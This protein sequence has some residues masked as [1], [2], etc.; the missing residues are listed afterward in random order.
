M[1]AF[2]DLKITAGR[3]APIGNDVRSGGINFALFSAHATKITLCLFDEDGSSEIAQLE[4]PGKT[5]NIWHGFVKGLKPGALYGYRVDGPYAPQDGHRFNA[6]KLLIDPYAKDLFG[7]FMQHDALYGYDVKSPEADMSFD[8]RDSAPY[9]PKCIAGPLNIKFKKTARPNTDM[10]DSIIYEAHIKGLTKRNPDV[11]PAHR[12]TLAGLSDPAMIT[13]LKDLGVTAIELLPVQSFF[14]EPRLTDM[15]LTNYWGY[16]PVNY[17]AM[18]KPYLGPAGAQSWADAVSALHGAG[19]EVILDVVYNHT[20]ESWELGPTLSY[21]GIDNVSYYRLQADKRYYVNHTGCGNTL[22]MSRPE[23][24]DLTIESLRYYASEMRVDGFRFDLGPILGRNPEAFDRG[25]A[26]FKAIEADP[27]LSGVKMIAEPWD[28]GP[29]GYQL[30][31]FPKGWSEW[32]DQYRDCVRSFW[33]GDPGAHQDMAGKLLGSAKN[34]DHSGRTPQAA[35]NFVAAHDGFTLTDTVS[36][37][38]KHNMANGEDN[39]DGHGHNLSENM[40]VEGP[41]D[42][43]FINAV[44]RKRKKNMLATLLLSQGVPMLLAGDE[45]GHSMQ[46][47]NNAYCQDNEITWLNWGG[48]DAELLDFTRELIALRKSRP[49]FT[50]TQ[51]MHGEAVTK[52]GAQ[53]ADWLRADGAKMH[54]GDWENPNFKA[55]ALLLTL[56]DQDTLAVIFN[57]GGDIEVPWLDKDWRREI[58]SAEHQSGHT[59]PADSVSVFAHK[60][61]YIRAD[62]YQPAVEKT[63][64]AYGIIDSYRDISGRVHSADILTKAALLKAMNADIFSGHIPP[65]APETSPAPQVYGAQTLEAHGGIWGVTCALYGLKSDRNWGVGDFEDLA[66]LC[67]TMAAK[68]ADFIGINPVHALFPSAPHLYAPYSPSSREFLNI[69]HIAPDMI[70]EDTGRAPQNLQNLRDAEIVDYGKIYAAKMDA[71]EAAFENFQTLPRTSN[72]KKDFA[73]FV[74]S[75]GKPLA[76]HALFDALFEA[77]PKSEQTYDG[78]HNFDDKYQNPNSAS[79]KTFAAQNADRIDFYTYLQWIAQTQI[80]AAQTRAMAAGMKTGLYLDFAVGVVPGGSDA[81]RRPKAFARGVS[82]GA[83]G[84]MANPDGQKWGLLPFD[85][86]HLAKTDFKDYRAALKKSLSLGGAVRI[87]HILGLLRSFWIPDKGGAGAYVRYPF[88]ALMT[89]IAQDSTACECVVFGEDLGTVPEGFRDA[90]AARGLMGCS[91][92]LIEKD[93]SGNI[94][95]AEHAR[96]LSMTGFSNHDF[97]TLTG[98]WQ[99]EDFKWRRALGIGDDPNVLA[100]EEGIRARDKTHLAHAAGYDSAPKIMDAGLMA[101]LQAWLAAAPALAF[102]VQLDD[103]LLEPHQPNVPGTTDSQPNWRRKSRLSSE[104]IKSDPKID[105][106]T[107][108]IHTARNKQDI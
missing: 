77:L 40:G 71:F 86:H 10:A 83:P 3:P 24:L 82:L 28:I 107:K 21:R 78:F 100:K 25:A 51:F 57:R 91:V 63:A 76:Q 8:P 31:G 32:S 101:K 33:K 26:F 74:K 94:I 79:C 2:T 22:D 14:S 90:M 15:G 59:I 97:P 58:T 61:P 81:W 50:Q 43:V 98:Y 72:R 47:N 108:A 1:S 102:A 30:G 19:I 23:V 11:A 29:G 35:I 46:G 41:T 89:M 7:E 68:G 56:P 73:I 80:E 20:A 36:Y 16:N 65:K 106:I 17:F 45:F 66:I 75:G 95:P 9:V 37:N 38:N 88:E 42:D 96:K 67:E 5:G 12:G 70:A 103:L 69:M 93:S 18:H 39:R 99:G 92:Q 84:D 64:Q 4:L 105:I 62:I 34:F 54:L 48:A 104:Q 49:H 60:G 6:N 13:Y 87:D 52:S 85:P 44:R 55:F 53:N 27:V